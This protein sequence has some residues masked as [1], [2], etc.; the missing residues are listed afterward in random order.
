MIDYLFILFAAY[1]IGSLPFGLIIGWLSGRI[2]IRNH[3]SGST[4]MTNVL[5]TVGTSA[6]IFVLLLDLGK[7]MAAVV[8]AKVITDSSGVEAVAALSSMVGHN[9]PIFSNF[10]G[11]KG[12]ATGLGA[13]III[14][15]LSA[16]IA[17]I[18][19]ISTV[20]ISRYVSLGSLVAAPVGTITL[21]ILVILN[22]EPI[23]YIWFGVFGTALITIRHNKN[24]S[25]LSKGQ[26]SKLG[27]RAESL[28]A[29][30]ISQSRKVE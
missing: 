18:V 21:I 4:G 29:K 27:E 11:G 22:I 13:M 7:A 1:L 25:R 14:S 8:L 5:R 12:V 2:D 6:A 19:G 9:W 15:P 17:S 10:K 24:L 3:G 30:V 28:K 16:L 26:E 20:A 23:P